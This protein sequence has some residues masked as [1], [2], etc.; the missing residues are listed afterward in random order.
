[1]FYNINGAYFNELEIKTYSSPSQNDFSYPELLSKAD[2]LKPNLWLK[3]D[4]GA[5]TTNDGTD[6]VTLTNNGTT[7]NAGISVRGNDSISLN[8]TNQYLTGT[9]EGMSNAS[10]SFSMQLYSRSGDTGKGVI[11]DIGT[12]ATIYLKILIGFGL[13]QAN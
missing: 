4:T 3:F 8:G 13:N 5:L 12:V 2:G 7:P 10:F 9:I 1:M 11:F 6:N